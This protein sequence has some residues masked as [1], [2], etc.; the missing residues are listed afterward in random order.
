V[1]PS[2]LGVGQSKSKSPSSVG[3]LFFVSTKGGRRLIANW[4][5]TA[6]FPFFNVVGQETETP[7]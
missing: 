5:E 2:G 7:L 6:P 4:T 3:I 1:Y